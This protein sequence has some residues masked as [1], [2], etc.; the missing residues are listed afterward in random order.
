MTH[1]RNLSNRS[2]DFV[3]VKDYGAVG[4][5]TTDD[6][7]AIQAA[8]AACA[9]RTIFFPSGAY[10]VSA[11]L[12]I[13][14]RTTL[15][16]EGANGN[17]VGVYPTSYLLKKSTMAVAALT[18][19]ASGSIVRGGGIVGQASNSG[20]GL[21]IL[22]NGI[23]ITDF[24]VFGMGRDGIRI[25]K[26]SA[27]ANANSTTLSNVISSSNTRYGIHV[28]DN[29]GGAPNANACVLTRCFTQS[30]GSHGV[31]VGNAAFNTFVGLL[32]ESNTGSGVR[33]TGYAF[34]NTF[35]GGDL[36]ANTAVDLYLESSVALSYGT[37][38]NQFIGISVSQPPTD[39]ASQTSRA[40]KIG[41]G[42]GAS[43][44]S[45]TVNGEGTWTPTIAGSTTAGTNTYAVQSGRWFKN[46]R[47]VTAL[48]DVL[49]A[50]N[51]VA[52]VGN[53]TIA[54]LP[55]GVLSANLGSFSPSLLS[56][57]TFTAS[58]SFLGGAVSGGTGAAILTIYD[59]G[60]N[61]G[62]SAIPVANINATA[63]RIAGTITYVTPD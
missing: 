53:I 45:G 17:G 13:A 10:L 28:H 63:G 44:G 3:S 42:Y 31:Y 6:T 52:M 37:G 49:L 39:L 1:A 41:N 14:S 43:G 26:D 50:S 25:G 38:G 60:S 61:V 5:G 21:E 32:S 18:I 20:D 2:T 8:I 24:S 62:F 34:S 59:F 7:A 23:S 4:D 9:G 30:N 27:G 58:T 48:F 51:T 12:S 19:S 22:G 29:P 35:V 54:G 55:F 57:V 56:Y 16:F 15:A 40:W 11:Q 47:M 33:L 46:G 36:E